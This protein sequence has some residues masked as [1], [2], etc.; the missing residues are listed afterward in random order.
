MFLVIN[1]PHSSWT[2]LYV[3]GVLAIIL[4]LTLNSSAGDVY[5]FGDAF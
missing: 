3:E 2:A 4:K 5:C 1:V